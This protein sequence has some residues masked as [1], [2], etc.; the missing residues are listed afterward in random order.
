MNKKFSTL[1][2]VLLAAGAWTT[3]DAKVVTVTTPVVGSS[4][5]IGSNFTDRA[6]VLLQSDDAAV[7]GTET[8]SS[9]TGKWTLV[10][11]SADYDGYFYLK[12]D[13]DKFIAA[14]KGSSDAA[15]LSLKTEEELSTTHAKVPFS[16][17]SGELVIAS[18]FPN[19][20]VKGKELNIVASTPVAVDDATNQH[21]AL[22]GLYSED[23]TTPGTGDLVISGG[24]IDVTQM[25]ASTVDAPLYIAVGGEYLTL[26]SDGV[27]VL[28]AAPTASKS[29][30]SSWRWEGNVAGSKLVS[31]AAER[32]GKD[33]KYLK[34]QP[35][36]GPVSYS[37]TVLSTQDFSLVEGNNATTFVSKGGKLTYTAEGEQN[38]GSFTASL[39]TTL[40]NTFADN[41]SLNTAGV[42]VAANGA[43]FT[44]SDVPEGYVLVATSN[45]AD[46][47]NNFLEGK[48]N[49]T[50]SATELTKVETDNYKNF[51]WKVSRS[52]NGNVYTYTFKNLAT[53]KEW[54]LGGKTNFTAVT[55]SVDGFGLSMDGTAV[56][57]AL[58]IVGGTPVQITFYEAPIAAQTKKQLNDILNP[59]FEVTL[60][61]SKDG[62][63]TIE[64]ADMFNGHKL[65]AVATGGDAAVTV[66]LW[67]KATPD[68][69][70][71]VLVLDKTAVIGQD[72]TVN[73]AFKWVSQKALNDDKD[74]NYEADF[75]FT[76]DLSN[77]T[78]DM[79]SALKIGSATVYVLKVDKRY[80]LT[81]LAN[82]TKDTKLPYIK[83]AA[84]NVYPVK[85]L[86]G[87]FLSFT[88]ADTKANAKTNDEEYKLDGVLA[89]VRNG[90]S[91]VADYTT[92]TRAELPEAQWAIVAADLDQNTFTLKNRE[93]NVTLAG[94]KLRQIAGDKFEMTTSATTNINRTNDAS[95]IVILTKTALKDVDM[96]DGY[97][98]ATEN[99]LR[100]E[101]F[102]LG[103]YH[104][105]AGNSN[106]YFVENHT[107]K[108]SHQIGM[109][110][111]KEDAQKWN[112]RFAMKADD[113]SKYTEVDTVWVETVFLTLDSDGKVVNDAKKQTKSKLA[114]LPYTFQNAS[115]SEFVHFNDGTKLEFYACDPKNKD[116]SNSYGNLPYTKATRFALK[117]KPNNTYNFVT[118]APENATDPDNVVA[119][120]LE[121]NK[122]YVA[123]S[124]DKG[125]LKKMNAYATDNNSLMVVEK[126]E[127]PE[128]H[129]IAVEWGDTIQLFRDENNSQVLYE[130]RD[131]KSVVAKNDT[132]SF[133]NIDNTHQFSVNPAIFADTAYVNRTIDNEA[134]TCYQYLLAVNV[135]PEKS[136]YCPYNPKHNTD[137]WREENG[138][139]CADAKE[140]RG[141][142]GRF[143]I[144]L[145]DTANVYGVTH[146][147][148]NWYIDE[149]EAG[150]KL[151][152][153]SFVEGYH[154]DDTLYVTRQG[155][156]TVKI[157]MDSPEFN[158]A[159]FAFR[160]VDNS[161]KTFKIQTQYKS[162]LG[163]EN[164]DPK[165]MA[166]YY[167][168]NAG[169]VT[170]E[171]YLKWIN[172]AVVVVRGYDKGD[173]FGIEE[174]YEGNPVA[175][176]DITASSIS[177][178]AQ[179]GKVVINGAAGKKVTISNVLGQTIANTVLSSDNATIAAPAGIVV[180]AVEGEAAVK[181]IIK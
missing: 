26:T 141:V 3:L 7:E 91:N 58:A 180:V 126:A 137:E 23:V 76:Y 73:G 43:K 77:P 69:K 2:A 112:L 149:D 90:A 116:N 103:Q 125:S 25:P 94:V 8:V 79:I 127:S 114:I 171:G 97:M 54:T 163:D 35:K 167:A 67:D 133:L 100:N 82:V 28:D 122:L 49:G 31:I 41:L 32:A 162:Y 95:D 80:I 158:V 30:A 14:L 132:L 51:L 83:L 55:N 105:V 38:L 24:V 111:E 17:V 119:T 19:D 85:E 101:K 169:T 47:K 121:D 166:D 106:A 150:E 179:E 181:A 136:Y 176:E 74:G 65:Y 70:S 75:Q 71:S 46:T 154:A 12:G 130:K 53:E 36:A 107:D 96:F 81:S 151:A 165:D 61:M 34:A 98:Q 4:Y 5:V 86:V 173:V 161:A 108:A 177:V 39:S 175:N 63:E 172:G 48:A 104:G 164:I 16:Y 62:K 22:F 159:K 148:N 10:D 60:K 92:V 123:N 40:H 72:K 144:N 84:S 170:D 78:T 102:Y 118:I 11:A 93:T 50:A 20:N 88:Y 59:G 52:A 135:D 145:I 117:M 66:Q 42:I 147:H 115:N 87:Q 45:T 146:L 9:A 160:Y 134:N 21:T 157:A 156:E 15:T 155:G 57:E 89:V 27:A 124:A 168:D 6:A 153:L 29:E 152:K 178:I 109:T 139:P 64:G 110:A 56:N 120:K 142:Y 68:A 129:K 44:G 143:L 37:S 1:V 128:Y 113:N 33:A 138:G 174:N 131:A 140:H 18:D 99:A 13:D